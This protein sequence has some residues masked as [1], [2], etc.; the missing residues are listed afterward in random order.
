VTSL[1]GTGAQ[2]IA[3]MMNSFHRKSLQLGDIDKN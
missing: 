1:S 2:S 3:G